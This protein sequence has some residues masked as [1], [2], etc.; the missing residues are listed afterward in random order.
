MKKGK[1]L[2]YLKKNKKDKKKKT[3]REDEMKR[4]SKDLRK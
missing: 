1:S 3:T 2:L 4:E